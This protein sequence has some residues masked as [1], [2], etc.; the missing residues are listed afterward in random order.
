MR[1]TLGKEISVD[2]TVVVCRSK[3]SN[4]SLVIGKVD[5]VRS[6]SVDYIV[7]QPGAYFGKKGNLAFG[8]VAYATQSHRVLVLE[9]G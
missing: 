6:D 5:R 3:G 2:D 8:D 9:D 1:D 4:T 7:I